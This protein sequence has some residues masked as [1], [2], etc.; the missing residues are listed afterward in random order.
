METFHALPNNE[1]QWFRQTLDNRQAEYLTFID[2]DTDL[3][4]IIC[5]DTVRMRTR[6]LGTFAPQSSPRHALPSQ[7]HPPAAVGSNPPVVVSS[8]DYPGEIN[9]SD[10]LAFEPPVLPPASPVVEVPPLTGPLNYTTTSNNRRKLQQRAATATLRK[11]ADTRR[12]KK[13]LARRCLDQARPLASERAGSASECLASSPDAKVHAHGGDADDSNADNSDANGEDA[14]DGTAHGSDSDGGDA[15]SSRAVSGPDALWFRQ[16]AR[17]LPGQVS[18][19][20]QAVILKNARS[21]AGPE[22]VQDWQEILVS[23]REEQQLRLYSRPSS[24][25]TSEHPAAHLEGQPREVCTFYYSYKKVRRSLLA[26]KF[27]SIAE[28]VNFANLHDAYTSAQNVLS[29]QPRHSGQSEAAARKKQLFSIL[30]PHAQGIRDPKSH[31]E[32]KSHWNHLNVQLRY[33]W[34]WH[35]FRQE[36]GFGVLGL[37]STTVFSNAWVHSKITRPQ[38]LLWIRAIK[39]FNPSCLLAGAQLCHTLQRALRGAKP[40]SKRRALEDVP[41]TELAAH[42][43][44]VVL[45]S[46]SNDG[47]LTSGD[48]QEE[49]PSSSQEIDWTDPAPFSF[50]NANYFCNDHGRQQH[51]FPMQY[52]LDFVDNSLCLYQNGAVFD[53]SLSLEEF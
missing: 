42:P 10:L 22:A 44:P 45:F 14:D 23:W 5:K 18:P 48:E 26:A 37:I 35:H 15:V 49:P 21:I 53:P 43:D 52:N 24:S 47:A 36:L 13:Q 34:R 3:R 17:S 7:R 2:P 20:R 28:R 38:F 4:L 51:F 50:G 6:V 31:P 9:E 33:A 8:P 40:S 19:T 11:L 39:S 30:Y 27:H 25:A 41:V 16:Q 12:K 32:F 46:G 1:I 29:S